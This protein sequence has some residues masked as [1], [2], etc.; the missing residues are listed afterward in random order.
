MKYTSRKTDTYEADYTDGIKKG[1]KQFERALLYR[2]NNFT[3]VSQR[4][5]YD[6]LED[7]R[8]WAKF[9]RRRKF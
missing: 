8:K 2:I 1:I 7:F 5:A 3:F 4:T 9:Y 6:V